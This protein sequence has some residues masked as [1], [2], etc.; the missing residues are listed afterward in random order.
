LIEEKAKRH[1]KLVAIEIKEQR[2]KWKKDDKER[3]PQQMGEYQTRNVA[4][5]IAVNDMYVDAVQAKLKLLE[6]I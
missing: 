5:T 6:Q 1:E 4:K 2:R 3:M